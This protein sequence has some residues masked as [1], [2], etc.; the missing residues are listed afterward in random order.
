MPLTLPVA[1]GFREI[2]WTPR[3]AVAVSESEFTLHQE[4]Y[5][6]DGQAR[7]VV[8]ELPA[9]RP[10]VAA[11]WRAFFLKCN[12]PENTFLLGD[13]V[14]GRLRGVGAGA[15]VYASQ[16]SRSEIVTTGWRANTVGILK[17]ADWISINDRLYEILDDADSDATG[18]ATLNIWPRLRSTP[19]AGTAILI[20]PAARGEFR[21]VGMPEWG[22]DTN[23]HFMELTFAAREV[24]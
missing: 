2:K 15:P 19:D 23:R 13:S 3:A 12:G 10:A 21:L 18:Q 24:L 7:D 5:A 8:V 17:Q 6:W 11:A 9:M 4:V 20:G 14:G 16:V 1:P 22:W